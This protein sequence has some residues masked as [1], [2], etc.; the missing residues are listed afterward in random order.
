MKGSS[1]MRCG[2]LAGDSVAADISGKVRPIFHYDGYKEWND[3][4]DQMQWE[5]AKEFISGYKDW[6]EK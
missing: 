3:E 4:K 5:N 1:K 2:V 6:L